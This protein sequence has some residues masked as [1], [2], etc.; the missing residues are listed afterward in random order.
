[1]IIALW[2][3]LFLSVAVNVLFGWYIRFAVRKLLF[4]SEN[5]GLFMGR[6]KEYETHLETVNAMET[7]YGDDIIMNLLKHTKSM[8]QEIKAYE[9]IYSLTNDNEDIEGKEEK[10]ENE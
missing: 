10:D 4:V 1:M 6:L 7:Y 3:L 5:I 8:M 9:S 2:I